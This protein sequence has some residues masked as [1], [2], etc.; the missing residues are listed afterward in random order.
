VTAPDLEAFVAGVEL[1]CLDAGNTIIFLDHAR[2]AGLLGSY[3][4]RVAAEDLVRCE[5]DAKRIVD[6]GFAKGALPTPPRWEHDAQ[7]GAKGWG[8]MLGLVFERAGIDPALVP[9]LLAKLWPE[10]VALNLWC[11]VPEGL[12]EAL[13]A[14]RA[15]GVKV[16]VV[17]NSEG[18]LDVLFERLGIARHLDRVIDSGKVGVEKP[19]PGIW[20]IALDAYPTRAD[21]VL[22]LGDTYTTDIAG[23]AALGFRAGLIDPFGH[24]AGWHA[25]VQRVPGVVEVARALVRSASRR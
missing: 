10:H 14:V 12:G 4:V 23:P 16:V 6:E 22:H 5:G 11:R 25:G 24:Y 18:M 3:G 1:L 13:D 2:L 17:S 15:L 8:R 19:H 21:R 7:P 20:Q 9:S